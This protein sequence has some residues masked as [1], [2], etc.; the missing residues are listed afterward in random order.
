[1]PWLAGPVG[2]QRLRSRRPASKVRV[3]DH[4]GVGAG[5][6]DLIGSRVPLR[7]VERG[8][9]QQPACLPRGQVEICHLARSPGALQQQVGEVTGSPSLRQ[10]LDRRQLVVAAR[11]PPNL[12]PGVLDAGV[13]HG[14]AGA[15]RVPPALLR[16]KMRDH[17]HVGLQRL[18]R[19]LPGEIL[20]EGRRG[21]RDLGHR[22]RRPATD[23]GVPLPFTQ[24][25]KLPSV[26]LHEPVDLLG[27][28][29]QRTVGAQ[30]AV[31]PF[32][33]AARQAPAPGLH[34]GDL[35][36]GVAGG[37]TA[38]RGERLLRVPCGPAQ[39]GKLAAEPLA[40]LSDLL[41]GDHRTAPLDCGP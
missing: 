15:G 21:S 35:A 10:R 2:D 32:P 23:P 16:R 24:L 11:Q 26:A 37:G 8:H 40:G 6:S 36:A 20:S 25:C 33:E 28:A 13:L 30:F 4:V 3:P 1:M 14:T 12:I 19:K 9:R 17:L 27:G 41:G 5:G 7:Q 34:V 31:E 38:G 22:W 18:I 39:L 29:Q